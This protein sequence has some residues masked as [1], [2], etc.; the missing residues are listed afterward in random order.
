MRVRRVQIALVMLARHD[1]HPLSQVCH[2]GIG[3]VPGVPVRRQYFPFAHLD[4]REPVPGRVGITLVDDLHVVVPTL[5]GQV[6]PLDQVQRHDVGPRHGPEGLRGRP[7]V[8]GGVPEHVADRIWPRAPRREPGSQRGQEHP[9]GVH[10][11]RQIRLGPR[12]LGERVAAEPRGQDDDLVAIARRHG[13]PGVRG[14]R[15]RRGQRAVRH[16]IG[17]PNGAHR[18]RRGCAR[19]GELHL[20]ARALQSAEPGVPQLGASGMQYRRR[21]VFPAGLDPARHDVRRHHQPVGQL[22][23]GLQ[24][25]WRR[26]R[27]RPRRSAGRPGQDL[28]R[29]GEHQLQLRPVEQASDRELDPGQSGWQPEDQPALVGHPRR[30]AARR[31]E[32]VSGRR[33]LRWPRRRIETGLLFYLGRLEEGLLRDGLRREEVDQVRRF[34]RR[35][36]HEPGPVRRRGVQPEIDRL[37]REHQE[38]I[39][40]QDGQRQR[41]RR[42]HQRSP[43]EGYG[44]YGGYGG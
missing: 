22:Q 34:A 32:R 17:R 43:A 28:R 15:V 1:V 39:G 6:I 41:R 16:E 24:A 14:R 13:G 11:H 42:V 27:R 36:M 20:L 23:R 9:A 30:N 29:G 26:D 4:Q 3:G 38:V 7:G 21:G 10:R 19:L 8:R 2:R 12:G 31:D 35:V 33:G 25:A 37:H 5:S 18:H 40:P 44:G